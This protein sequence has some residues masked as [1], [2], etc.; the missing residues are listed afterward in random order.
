MRESVPAPH[1][2]VPRLRLTTVR[3]INSSS[4]Q[5]SAAKTNREQLVPIYEARIPAKA[6][7]AGGGWGLKAIE[8]GASEP[9]RALRDS[10]NPSLHCCH[11]LS[12]CFPMILRC[13]PGALAGNSELTGQSQES[14]ELGPISRTKGE[15]GQENVPCKP[16]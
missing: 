7:A 15:M 2:L 4:G 5:A 3:Q 12:V 14:I 11:L 9:W 10:C 6:R 16:C 1:L 13:S 8:P